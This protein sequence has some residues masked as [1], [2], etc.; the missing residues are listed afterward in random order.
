[1]GPFLK[2]FQS[3]WYLLSVLC[4]EKKGIPR[5]EN[6]HHREMDHFTAVADVINKFSIA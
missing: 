3:I 1:M 4:L 5:P 2:M 6:T